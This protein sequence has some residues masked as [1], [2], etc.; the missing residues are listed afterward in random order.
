MHKPKSALEAELHF[1]CE[2]DKR[3]QEYLRRNF[4]THVGIFDDATELGKV[5]ARTMD[6]S[7]EQVPK[8]TCHW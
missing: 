1:M 3:K 7:T 4:P 2:N 6:G 5:H 8:A